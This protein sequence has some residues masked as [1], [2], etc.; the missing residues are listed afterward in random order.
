MMGFLPRYGNGLDIICIYVRLGT[1]VEEDG[2]LGHFGQFVVHQCGYRH[3]YHLG[4]VFHD[5]L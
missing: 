3:Q 5:L 4:G 1:V 2:I